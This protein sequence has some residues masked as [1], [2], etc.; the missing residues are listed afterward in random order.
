MAAHLAPH[1]SHKSALALL[2]PSLITPPI[3]SIR[4]VHD[5]HFA[6]WPPHIN[7]IYPFLASPSEDAGQQGHGH[8]KPEPPRLK[9]DIRL[10]I[11]KAVKH[12][13]PFRVALSADPPGIFSHSK[14]S[15][16]VWLGPSPGAVEHLQ[17][18][19][20]AEFSECDSDSRPFT[21]HLSV[22]QA[23][24]DVEAQKLGA[25]LKRSISEHLSGAGENEDHLSW[26]VDR[27]YV[28]ERKG[29]HGRFEI[30]D[31]IELLDE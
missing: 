5:K 31:A 11:Q 1:L 23:H 12:V 16:T 9:Q 10:R 18:A 27:V 28:I 21:P 24:S 8:G 20:Q 3:E 6:R 30:V 13:P 29:Y 19:L 17:A 22:G 15:K 26:Y 25:E 7:L 2:P 14:R 4:R